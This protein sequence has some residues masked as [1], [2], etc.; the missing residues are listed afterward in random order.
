MIE[1]HVSNT[2]QALFTSQAETMIQIATVIIEI[3]F[4]GEFFICTN[5][6]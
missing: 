6:T 2:S 5:R 1:L 3:K 4:P